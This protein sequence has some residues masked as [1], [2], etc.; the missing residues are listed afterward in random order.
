MENQGLRYETFKQRVLEFAQNG[1]T[2]PINIS[3]QNVL[4]P[5]IKNGSVV[6]QEFSKIYR[7]YI[8]KGVICSKDYT[9][10]HFGYISPNNL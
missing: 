4:R 10:H 8:G 3:Y 5:S 2:N 9:V 6:S 7:P 1:Y